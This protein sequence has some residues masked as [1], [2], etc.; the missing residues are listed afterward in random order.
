MSNLHHVSYPASQTAPTAKGLIE[1]ATTDPVRSQP[2]LSLHG[3]MGGYDQGILLAK[4][5][6]DPDLELTPLAISRPGYLNSPL[7]SAKTPVEQADLFASLLDHLQ[8]ERAAVIAISAGGPSAI[9]FA[10]RHGERCSALILVSCCAGHLPI[11]RAISMRLM[12]MKI[13]TRS[14]RAT[15]WLQA[16]AKA[17][18]RKTASRSISDPDLLEQTIAN[19]KAWP[20]MQALQ[21]CVM[22]RMAKR[23]PG[24]I[25]DTAQFNQPMALPF[26]AIRCPTLIIH[27]EK[28]PV[29]PFAHASNAARSIEK[30]KLVPLQ[31]AEHVALFTHL[32]TVRNETG[33][34]LA[35]AGICNK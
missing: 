20:M 12:L 35:E 6:I 16:K 21:E 23:L 3:G 31:D 24:T 7:A 8:I 15:R 17:D 9:E 27:G 18:P 2:I 34:F 5:A 32:Q 19:E 29:V 22:D 11:R 30:A 14:A 13:L 26:A 28:D 10:A 25:N 4:A 33:R 1:Y